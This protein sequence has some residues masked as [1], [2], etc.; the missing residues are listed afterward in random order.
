[1]FVNSEPGFWADFSPSTVWQ[2][3]ARTTPGVVGQPVASWQL[4]TAS[5]VIYAVVPGDDNRPTLQ[6]ENGRYFL[7]FDN[8]N[9]GFA[10]PAI[11]FTGTDQVTVVAGIRKLGDAA[12]G[13]LLELSANYTANDGV[14]AIF[15]PSGA[16]NNYQWISGGTLKV[17][18]NATSF[19]SPITSVITTLA[20]I[21]LDQSV[22]RVNGAQVATNATN[23]G[24]GNYGNHALYIGRRGAGT[25]PFN[26]RL[27]GLIVRGVLSDAA[28]ITAAEAWM[29][30]RTG[31]Y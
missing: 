31:A 2:D 20:D 5:G 8:V 7:L 29:N 17:L 23:Q 25:A 24:A 12:S 6:L 27:Y 15:A 26:G 4:N 18:T 14:F 10:T 22:I 13:A 9:D 11:N 28:T 1:M 16:G 19:V 30:A 21:S 3:T